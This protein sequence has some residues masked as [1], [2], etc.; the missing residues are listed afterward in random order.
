MNSKILTEFNRKQKVVM[1]KYFSIAIAT[2]LLCGCAKQIEG[3]E[4]NIPAPKTDGITFVAGFTKVTTAAGVN[5]WEADDNISIFSAANGADPGVAIDSNLEY[6]TDAAGA[7]AA[8]TAVGDLAHAT[9]KY[10][11]YHPYS[12]SYAS[13]LNADEN[14]GFSAVA[15]GAPVTDYRFMPIMVNSGATFIFDPATGESTSSSTPKY[16]Y[17]QADAPANEEDP[18]VLNFKPVLPI[19]ELDLYGQGTLKEVDISFTDP[20]T[21]V[22]SDYNWLTAKGVFNTS[23]GVMTMT[24]HSN[25]YS[26]IKVT[27]KEESKDYITLLGETPMKMQV[28]VGPFTI[29]KGLTLKFIDKDGKTFSKAIWAD[30]VK[31]AIAS[32]GSMKHIRQGINVP[33]IAASAPSVAEFAAEGGTS[34]AV[35][36]STY[37]AWSVKSKPEWITV[38]PASGT[39]NTSVTFTAAANSGDARNGDVVFQTAEG[40][41]CSVA[42][43]QARVEIVSAGYYSVDVSAITFADSYIYDVKNS[44]NILIARITK[45]YLGATQNVQVRAAY[46]ILA[47]GEPD[48]AHGL[49]L[50][51]GGTVNAWTMNPT[52]VTYAE[53]GSGTIS[54]IWVKDDGSDI[55]TSQPSGDISAASVSPY[56]LT[57]PSGQS[58]AIVK[59]GSQIWTAEGYKSTK[60][61]N[62]DDYTLM[63][64]GTG[65]STKTSPAVIV[66]DDGKY[67]FNAHAVSANFAPAGWTLPSEDSNNNESDWIGGYCTFVG[68]Y[69]NVVSSLLFDRTT[70]KLNGTALANLGYYNTWSKNPSG[71]KWFMLMWKNGANPTTNAQAMTAMFEVRLLKK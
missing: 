16:Y 58:H 57:S 49:V 15:A 6:K 27:V 8:F 69:G 67:L 2:L 42:V 26:T 65:Y 32:D 12:P 1:K 4:N 3:P 46:P 44:S 37:S 45:E 54:T 24:N 60:D 5:T 20:A 28:I 48:Y 38:S 11:A 71:T 9:D 63:N 10:F 21:D 43:S 61:T 34:D 25:A 40:N 18:V 64:S 70:W 17:A 19:L 30:E 59:I 13:K 33:Y 55:L 53:G 50:D 7:S 66:T 51:D 41:E 14:I 68:A 47:S 52:A 56:T 62:G 31:S 39:G 35:T 22:F 23:T 36:I 29:Q